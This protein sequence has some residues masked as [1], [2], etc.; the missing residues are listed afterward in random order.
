M[1]QKTKAAIEVG[2]SV[3][4]CVGE[5]LAE[6]EAGKTTEV[7]SEQLDEVVKVIKEEEWRYVG[8]SI[9][10]QSDEADWWA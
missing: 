7:V 5:T 4:L 6:R 9:S 8:L 10:I 2:L 3:I 1:A